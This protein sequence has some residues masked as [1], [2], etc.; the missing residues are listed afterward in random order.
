MTK[1][2]SF[3][4]WN[5]EHF[6]G[7]PDRVS[8]VVNLL[9]EKDPD[10]FAIYE[11]QG[12]HV[13]FDLMEKLPTHSFTITENTQQSNMEILVG[14][15]NVIP[16][17]VTQREEFR[18][19]VPTLRPGAL[20]TLRIN[21]EDYSILFLHVKSYPD[22]R[23][24]GL[25]DDMF[26]HASSLKRKLD[27]N[28]GSEESANFICLGDLNTMGLNATFNDISDLSGDQEIDVLEKRMTSVKMRKL[29]KTHDESWWN[30]KDNYDP[31]KLDHVF[32]AN[33]LNFKKFGE[34]EVQVVGWPEK[35]T[36]EQKKEWIDK[37]S[38]HALLYA[39]VVEL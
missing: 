29:K 11:V 15:R 17:F 31:S 10:V 30:G 23:S 5:V 36:K 19:K 22:P 12:K 1:I 4:S 35:E 21:S 34:D 38:D 3:A 14:V 7:N 2:L 37:Y 32:A 33:Q 24:W 26:K 20:A 8:R 25:R 13:Y 9:K 39:E 28:V 6:H 27:K 16:S 18:G